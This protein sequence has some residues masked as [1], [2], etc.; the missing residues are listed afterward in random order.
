[1]PW[2]TAPNILH[3]IQN[4]RLCTENG[5]KYPRTARMAFCKNEAVQAGLVW[6]HDQEY[7][8]LTWRVKVHAKVDRGRTGLQT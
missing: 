8:T 6:P 1:M 4:Q 5:N 3:G 7:F 2:K